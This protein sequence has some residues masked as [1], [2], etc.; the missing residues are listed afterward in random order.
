MGGGEEVELNNS[1]TSHLYGMGIFQWM[2]NFI[3]Y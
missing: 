2:E 3:L 1:S